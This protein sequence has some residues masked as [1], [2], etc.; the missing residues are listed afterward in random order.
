[1]EY[2]AE[3]VA[4]FY[5][6]YGDREWTRFEDGRTSSLSL[7]VHRHYID[8]F[9]RAGDRVLDVGAGPGR[10]TLQLAE[11]GAQVTVA[12]ISDRQLELNRA[13]LSAAGLAGRIESLVRADIVDL[14]AFDDSQFDVVVCYGGPLSYVLDRAS[15][16]LR[17]LVRVL[18]PGGTLLLSVMSLVG[19]TAAGLPTVLRELRDI[20]PEI[21]GRVIATGE[22]SQSLSGHFDMRMYRW[23]QLEGLLLRQALVIVAASASGLAFGR[24]HQESIDELT[25][26]ELAT[27][28]AWVIDLAAEPG[29]VDMGEHIIAVARKR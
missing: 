11:L 16:A 5:D 27:V 22:L 6:D 23:R 17:E 7:A 10:F 29:A 4:A 26:D 3:R 9:V 21:I 24:L 14:G 25:P 8:R 20:G 28:T 2:D 19:S 18:K 12:D 15:D 13:R 1:M